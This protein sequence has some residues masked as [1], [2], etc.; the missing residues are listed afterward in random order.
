MPAVGAEGG[1]ERR[2]DTAAA[3]VLFFFLLFWFFFL[4]GNTFSTKDTPSPQLTNG[5]TG[6]LATAELYTHNCTG[7]PWLGSL[8]CRI[9]FHTGALP[10][11]KDGSRVRLGIERAII[12][13]L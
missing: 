8:G 7:R 12:N 2:T 10:L 11:P 9:S 1:A 3:F 6:I 4:I 5:Y 13:L